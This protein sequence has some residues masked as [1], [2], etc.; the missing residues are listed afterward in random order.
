[1]MNNL[2][3]LAL[4][5]LKSTYLLAAIVLWSSVTMAQG[6]KTWKHFDLDYLA[7][8][9]VDTARPYFQFLDEPSFSAGLYELPADSKDQQQPHDFDEIYY[10]T[11]GTATLVVGSDSKKVGPGSIVYVK[12]NVP[13]Q[14]RDIEDDLQVLVI[15]SKTPSN[16][17]GADWKTVEIDKLVE[18]RDPATNVWNLFL[19]VPTMAFG[20][21]MLPGK[22]G[23]DDLLTH[24]VD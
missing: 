15:F 17:K 3:K 20:L 12:A 11:K 4:T 9:N 18:Q 7:E 2:H 6:N 19:D 16:S 1:M 21:Y 5:T 10:V 13:H 23:G 8:K 14:F 24:K 22:L